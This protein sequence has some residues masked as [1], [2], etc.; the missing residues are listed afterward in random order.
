MLYML[1]TATLAARN[2]GGTLNI[3]CFA[4]FSAGAWLKR[5]S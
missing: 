4:V 5:T 3:E 2:A 1:D